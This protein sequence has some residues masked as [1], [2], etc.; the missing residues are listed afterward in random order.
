MEHKVEPQRELG[1]LRV[2]LGM[3]REL[4][5]SDDAEEVLELAGRAML[6]L[7]QASTA[8]LVL[9]GEGE[10]VVA[11]DRGGRPH[12]AGKAHP[13]YGS[14]AG[15]LG[16]ARSTRAA[17][18]GSAS[19]HTPES[20][21]LALAVPAPAAVAALVVGWDEGAGVQAPGERR[22]I[23]TA[24]LE[25]TVAAL[26]KIQSHG[27]LE[28]L[29]CSQYEQMADTAQ[30]HADELARRDVTEQEMRVLSMIDVLT[31]LNNRRGFFVHAEQVFKV[32]QRRHARCAVIFADVDRLKQVNDELGHE[33]GDE[34]IRDAAAVFRE[35]FREADVVARFGGDE[36]VAFTLDDA[37]PQI[38]LARL[39]DN[40]RAFNLMQER[41]YEVSISAGIVQCDPAADQ[42]LL[43]YVL[44]ADQKMYAQ[45]RR[46][47]H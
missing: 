27:S 25:L 31:G 46:H 18:D 14:A 13:W 17:P 38:V 36:F 1:Q 47:L 44:L 12:A 20:G 41:Q 32:A 10:H 22:R 34:L 7:T 15:M 29:V 33:A 4:L 35:T 5:Q 40:L 26:G 45:K 43:S 8:L 30:A 2:L 28:R 24:I 42:S 21:T 6:E 11:F 19:A 37:Q 16:G 9:R 3:S 23:L 39:R